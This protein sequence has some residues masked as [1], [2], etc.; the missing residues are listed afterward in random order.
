M[1]N[2]IHL[3]GT[4]DQEVRCSGE[5]NAEICGALQHFSAIFRWLL[6]CALHVAMSQHANVHCLGNQQCSFASLAFSFRK[7]S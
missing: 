1:P 2:Y 5:I 6:P 4:Q 3:H 7:D